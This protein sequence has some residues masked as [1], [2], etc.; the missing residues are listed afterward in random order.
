M[1][2]SV[3]ACPGESLPSLTS[4]VTSSGSCKRR[5]VLVTYGRDLPIRVATSSCVRPWFSISSRIPSAASIALRSSRCKFSMS[6]ISWICCGVNSLMIAGTC[7][8]PARRLALKRRSP[9]IIIYLPPSLLTKMSGCKT[10]YVAI[11]VD[12]SRRLSSE[13]VFLG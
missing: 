7:F 10:P 9:A 4:S 2:I 3:L 8:R 12:I 6:E 13:K 1:E 11:D 5:K